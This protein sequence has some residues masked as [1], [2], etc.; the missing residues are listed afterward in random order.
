MQ[1]PGKILVVSQY[2][3]PDPSTT[4]VYMTAIAEGL[5]EDNEVVV[6]TSSPNSGSRASEDPK[7]PTVIEI[8]NWTPQ[9]DALVKRAI[10]I[11]LLALRMFF[12]TLLRARRTDIV[13]CVTTPFTLPYAVILAAK[14]R[15]AATALLIY[16]L[17]PE[18]LERA[19]LI[20]PRSMTARLIRLA[21]TALFR[22]LDAIVTIGRDVEALLLAYKGVTPGKINFIPNWTLLPVGYRELSPD[23]RFRAGRRITTDRR[24]IGKSGLHP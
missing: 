16:D 10:A 12:S 2:Y 5:A 13:F 24:A 9:K 4:A 14:L 3:V 7:K 8:R 11:S 19:E 22:S 15:G 1:K 18:A 17:Y 20:K 21:N 23:N 6:L